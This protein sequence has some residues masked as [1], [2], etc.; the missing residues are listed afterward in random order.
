[1]KKDIFPADQI[2]EKDYHAWVKEISDRFRKSQ[3]TPAWGRFCGTCFSY[4]VGTQ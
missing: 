1:M 4:P 3:L 2:N